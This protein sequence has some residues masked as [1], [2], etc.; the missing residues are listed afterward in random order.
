LDDWGRPFA[1]RL[2]GRPA[3]G[4]AGFRVDGGQRRALFPGILSETENVVAAAF[5]ESV[6]RAADMLRMAQGE[7]EVVGAVTTA[8]SSARRSMP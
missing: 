6:V 5:E 4:R 1:R 8:P 2:V 7:I 3:L